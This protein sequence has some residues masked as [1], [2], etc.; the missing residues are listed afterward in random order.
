MTQLSWE[1]ACKRAG[2]IAKIRQF[3]ADRGVVEVETPYLS[4][5]TITDVHLDAFCCDFEYGSNGIENLYLQTSPEFALKRLLSLGYGD[6]YQLGKAFRHEAFGTK[7][8]PEF[9]LLEWYRIGF[10]EHQL[11][12]ELA[13]LLKLILGCHSVDKISYQQLFLTRLG[14]DP[15]LT[16]RE[17]LL[18]V[19][20]SQNKYSD[21][22]ADVDQDTLLQ[23]IFSELIEPVFATEIPCFVH[24]F[25]ASQACLAK[26][27]PLDS[28]V[29]SRFECYFK[30]IELANGFYEL[31]DAIIQLQRFEEDNTKRIALGLPAKPID[32]R[33]VDA[34]QNGLPECSGVA[35][36]IDR[37]L[38]LA[39]NKSTIAEVLTFT[40]DEA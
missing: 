7:H 40:I 20:H 14:L 2:L 16:S 39:M 26:I 36:G 8:N 13:D 11:M 23:F 3:F 31:T 34:L 4:H 15:L 25:P 37:L 27:N 12:T 1:D 29:A 18:D 35:V 19:I 38:M 6:I 10:N 28:R 17:E 24:D 32:Y 30:G 33:F 22:L 5:G 21:W 9:T